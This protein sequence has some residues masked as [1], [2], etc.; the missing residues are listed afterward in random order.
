MK[1]ERPRRKKK[2]Q[3]TRYGDVIRSDIQSKLGGLIDVENNE[4]YKDKIW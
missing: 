3:D 4:R 2:K 1:T